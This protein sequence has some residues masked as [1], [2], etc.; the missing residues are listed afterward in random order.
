VRILRQIRP[1]FANMVLGLCLPACHHGV[2]L[3]GMTPQEYVAAEQPKAVRVTASSLGLNKRVTTFVAAEPDALVLA[4]GTTLRVPWGSV[5]RLDI[6]A[7]YRNQVWLGAGLGLVAGEGVGL[8]L[9]AAAS[10]GEDQEELIL[11]PAAGAVFGTLVGALVG[12]LSHTD[13]WLSVP[14]DGMQVSLD[15]HGTQVD[16][17]ARLTF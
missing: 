11:F 16:V 1:T 6:H 8:G 10:G 5:E 2:T 7:G 3:E 14:L 13:R 12:L 17:V 4:S 15:A 9:A